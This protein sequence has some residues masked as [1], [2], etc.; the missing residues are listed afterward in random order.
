MKLKDCKIL[1]VVILCVQSLFAQKISFQVF[2]QKTNETLPLVNVFESKNVFLGFTNNNGEVTVNLNQ[3]EAVLTFQLLG[4]KTVTLSSVNI[5]KIIKMEADLEKLSAVVISAKKQED[6]ELTQLKPVEGTHIYAGKKSE[7]VNLDLVL[8]NKAT[9]NARQIYAKVAGL[10]IYD[11]GDGGLQ[12]NIG[13][14]GLDPNRTANFNT[15]QNDYDISADVL[16]YPESYYTPPSEAID[17]IQIVRG[18]ASLQYGTQLGGLVNFKLKKPSKNK[19][20]ELVTR[21]SVGSFTSLSNFTGIGGTSGKLSYYA[22]GNF[23]KGDGFRPNS[24]YES[25]SLYGYLNYNFNEKTSISGEVTYFYYLAQQAGGLSDVQFLENPFQSNFERN[26]FEVN[27]K[28]FNLKLNHQFS[29]KTK[30]SLSL[31]ALSSSRNA[32][33]FRGAVSNDVINVFAKEEQDP[34]TGEFEF[35]RDLIIDEFLNYGAEARIITEYDLGSQKSVLLL[36]SKFYKADNESQQGPGSRGTDADFSFRTNEFPEFP[37]Q[38]KFDFPNLNISVFGENIFNITD[39]FSVTPGFRFEYI[40]TQTDGVFTDLSGSFP[41]LIPEN[42]DLERQ[43]VLLGVG[44]S[45]KP[46]SYFESYF[47]F[48]QNYRSVTFS[49]IRTVRPSFVIDPNIKDETGYN[50]D[51][52][53]RGRFK[54]KL[55]YDLSVFSLL[56]DN[57]IGSRFSTEPPFRSQIVRGNIGQ[58]VIIG[59]ESLV[60]WNIKETFFS[61]YKDLQLSV[62]SNLAFTKSE[63]TSGTES[64]IQGNEVEFVPD[65]NLKTGISFGYKNLLS[66]LQYTFISEQFTD[67]TNSPLDINNNRNI[68]GTIPSYDILDLSTSYKFSKNIKLEAGISNV[69]DNVYFTRRATGYPGPGIIPSAPRSYYATLEI[70]F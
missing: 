36:G 25:K 30:G 42:K 19:P 21:N 2:D 9:N 48:S 28:L 50:I 49:D 65:V 11:N 14:R 8:A 22:F 70:K 1:V 54:K 57:R 60:Q 68:N 23:K 35:G 6:Y 7:V 3:K 24:G 12:L 33:G 41:T 15:R 55:S 46:Q 64:N 63:Y 62:F 66:S 10:N 34:I 13:G 52:G 32:I 61:N 4:Y 29:E 17:K 69:L 39:N 27:W 56:Y 5:P 38:S 44:L 51:I 16:G 67:A 40:R 31:F 37:N 45:Y 20:I 47:N 18:A 58:A 26:W 53:I 43:F 59:L